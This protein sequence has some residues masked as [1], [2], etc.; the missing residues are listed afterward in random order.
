MIRAVIWFLLAVAAFLY[1]WYWTVLHVP[2]NA[3]AFKSGPLRFVPHN[4]GLLL[5]HLYFSLFSSFI[6]FLIFFRTHSLFRLLQTVEYA[7]TRDKAAILAFLRADYSPLGIT[8]QD[9]LKLV[10]NF[11]NTTWFV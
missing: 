11:L 2:Q 4:R 3:A 7:F 10:L 8:P 1:F 5:F 6:T 9:Q